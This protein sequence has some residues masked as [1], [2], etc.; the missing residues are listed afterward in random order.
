M[1][2]I[3]D[4]GLTLRIILSF[5]AL[6]VLYI[7]FLSALAYLGI[8][9]IALL[10]IGVFM[11]FM[12]YIFSDK[13]VLWSSKARIVSKEEYPRLHEVT[14]RLVARIGLQ[15]PKLAVIYTQIP[16]AFATGKSKSSAVVA[17]TTGLLQMLNDEELEGVIAHELAHIK[18][19]DM[20]AITMASLLSI[21]AWYVLRFGPYTTYSSR[22]RNNGASF[23]II[24]A[25]ITWLASFLITRAI[26]RYREFIADRDGAMMTGKPIKLANA[27]MKISGKIKSIP[28][29]DLRE[30][31]GLNAFFIIPAIGDSLA[32]LF[33]THPPVEERIKRLMALEESMH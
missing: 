18:N 30:V 9:G 25:L 4:V 21:I 32:N 5:L 1:R 24:I 20:L 2:R 13:I 33:A 29:K 11:V 17:V 26:S 14:E 15:K 22:D 8:G 31:E 10:I 7:I 23:I 6:T 3:N 16:N 28:T 27:L 19:R 12:Q